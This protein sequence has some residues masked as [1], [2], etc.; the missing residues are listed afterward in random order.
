M[1]RTD[2]AIVGV[3]KKDRAAVGRQNAEN[4]TRRARHQRIGLIAPSVIGFIDRY[5]VGRMDLMNRC[6]AF[7]RLSEP[8]RDTGAVFKHGFAG[9]V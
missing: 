7:E 3:G 6:E 1:S 5:H 2:H 8:A 9:V 4:E